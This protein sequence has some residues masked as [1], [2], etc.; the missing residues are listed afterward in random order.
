M[1]FLPVLL[2]VFISLPSI[3]IGNLQKNDPCEAAKAGAVAATVTAKDSIFKM[4]LT[5][6]KSAYNS[7]GKEHCI[8]LGK[9]AGGILI[10]S[11]IS[12]GSA[13]SSSVPQVANAFA[14]L[15]NHPNNTPPDAGDFYGLAAINKTNHNYTTRFAVMPDGTLYALL[16]TD[17]AAL[18]TFITQYAPQLPAYKGGPP[19]FPAAITDEAREMKYRQ[20]C[21]DEMV[22]A[23]ILEKYKTGISL[24]KQNGNGI[25]YK[26]VT[27]IT[28]NKNG[29]VYGAGACL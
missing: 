7:D 25:F 8:S 4:A 28:K 9:N 17:T 29:F 23:L 5:N 27:T 1:I 26:I 11:L 21:T 22:L 19:G 20:H 10:A 6:I 13:I 2:H 15:H 12:T 18:H 14:D 3:C 24:L 16:V